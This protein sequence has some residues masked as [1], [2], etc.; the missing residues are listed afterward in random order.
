[1]GPWKPDL[2]WYCAAKSMT[3]FS[4]L[5]PPKWVEAART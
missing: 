2:I 5:I 4:G 1:M 3:F